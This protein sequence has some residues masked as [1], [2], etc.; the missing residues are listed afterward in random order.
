MSRLTRLTTLFG[1]FALA[2]LPCAAREISG[3]VVTAN[4]DVVPFATVTAQLPNGRQLRTESAKDG[5]F[6]LTTPDGSPFVI[7]VTG[8]FLRSE[9]I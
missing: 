7:I 1:L 9:P 8:Q 4:H 5:Q 3:T 2:I 6:H